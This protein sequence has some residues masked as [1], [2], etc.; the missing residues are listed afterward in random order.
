M[1]EN[2]TELGIIIKT[3][4]A[5]ENDLRLTLFTANGIRYATAK[6]VLKPK[7][8]MTSSV[9]LFTVAEFSI[10]GSTVTG[11]AV[12]S[13]P[14]AISKDI[15][16]Y[17]LANTIADSLL[18]LEFVERTPEALV[19]SVNAITELSETTKSCYRIFIEYYS[20]ILVLLGY[21]IQLNYDKDKELK[22]TDAKKIVQKIISAFNQNADYAIKFTDNLM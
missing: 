1:R 17:Y 22:L 18:H 16:R 12:L 11:I 3:A 4:K 20:Q 14:F 10:S 7:A 9:G 2:T 19:L 6:G 5:G 15:N 21:A 8:K 13:S